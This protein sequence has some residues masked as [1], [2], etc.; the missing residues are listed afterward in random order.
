MKHW[1]RD[2]L[3][4]LALLLCA[5]ALWFILRP[6]TEGSFA[7]VTVDGEEY[8][9]YSLR[10]DLCIPIGEK[11]YNVLCISGGEAYISDANCGDHTCIRTGKISREGEQII[12]LPHQLIVTVTGGS[13]S[14][15]D[16]STN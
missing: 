15:I 12:C 10:E 11:A 1:K 5:A 3:L 2:T 6:G 4:I 16:A 8:G 13:E 7:V 9:R 14:G